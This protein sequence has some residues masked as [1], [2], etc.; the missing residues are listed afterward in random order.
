[1]RHGTEAFGKKS[2][3]RLSVSGLTARWALV[4]FVVLCAA[5]AFFE[6]SFPAWFSLWG[7]PSG[8][9]TPLVDKWVI[10]PLATVVFLLQYPSYAVLYGAPWLSNVKPL[11]SV[12]LAS[13]FSMVV[14]LP[15][16]LWIRQ[17][18]KRRAA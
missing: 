8:L 1:M 15:L 16:T 4:L 17:H 14:Y 9:L 12:L 2:Q 6:W 11:L 13:V 7:S 18:A 3:P 10:A 5:N